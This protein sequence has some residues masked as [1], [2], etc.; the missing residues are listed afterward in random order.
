MAPQTFWSSSNQTSSTCSVLSSSS[1]L[2]VLRAP[3]G[4]PPPMPPRPASV[5]EPTMFP[6]DPGLTMALPFGPIWKLVPGVPVGSRPAPPL[7]APP[8]PPSP[9]PANPPGAAIG[10]IPVVLATGDPVRTGPLGAAGAET[11]GLPIPGSPAAPV[12]GEVSPTG[13]GDGFVPGPPMIPS[14]GS[15]EPPP[16]PGPGSTIGTCGSTGVPGPPGVTPGPGVVGGT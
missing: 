11:T 14:T 15:S 8:G 7:V 10:P 16:G 3:I 13:S 4:A 2:L 12:P 9:P 6:A 5:P 1:R